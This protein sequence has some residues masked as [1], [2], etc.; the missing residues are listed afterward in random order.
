MVKF[1]HKQVVITAA[2]G[3]LTIWLFRLDLNND[4]NDIQSRNLESIVLPTI[5]QNAAW[6]SDDLEKRLVVFFPRKK[7]PDVIKVETPTIVVPVK[8]TPKPVDKTLRPMFSLLD[9]DH[10]VG[11]VAI[12]QE[13]DDKFAILKK[14]NFVSRETENIKVKEATEFSGFTLLIN[15]QTQI[16]LNNQNK[17]IVLNLFKPR[18]S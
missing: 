17:E 5:E 13:S 18:N 1:N 7:T 10:Q 6:Q 4:R 15:S 16:Q 8:P 12:I 14:I 11:L 9:K 2:L 3:C